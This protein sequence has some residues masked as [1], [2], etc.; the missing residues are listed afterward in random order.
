MFGLS[1]KVLRCNL[2]S[3]IVFYLHYIIIESTSK[4]C[5]FTDL[6]KADGDPR[7]ERRPFDRETDLGLRHMDAANRKSLIK[8]STKLN[9]KFEHSKEGPTYL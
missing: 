1:N 2:S 5:C 7:S 9:S 4:S 6:Q 8:R 3:G